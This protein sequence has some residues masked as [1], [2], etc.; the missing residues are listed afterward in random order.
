[1]ATV[2]LNPFIVARRPMRDYPIQ[3][4]QH[5]LRAHKPSIPASSV[6]GI[7]GPNT[8][9]RVRA[10]QA[11]HPPLVVDGIVGR[12]TWLKLI[13]TIR[14]GSTGSAVKALQEII[15]AQDGSGEA[16]P[17]LVDG[18]FGPNTD[19]FVRGMQ[20]FHELDDDGIVGPLTWQALLGGLPF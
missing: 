10:F 15:L 14:Q 8:E 2:T 4:L 5:L 3:S 17:S 6:D 11:S 18:I 16:S 9:T 7:F 19:G 13:I 20:R 1:M 12:N